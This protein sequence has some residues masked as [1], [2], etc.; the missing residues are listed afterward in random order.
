MAARP[1]TFHDF[2]WRDSKLACAPILRRRH[3]QRKLTRTL[4]AKPCIVART[5]WPLL[6]AARAEQGMG[7]SHPCEGGSFFAP[8]RLLDV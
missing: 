5:A 7:R 6:A 8:K 1:P 4:G 2:L 3:L